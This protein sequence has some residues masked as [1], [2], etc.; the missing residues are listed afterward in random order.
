MYRSNSPTAAAMCQNIVNQWRTNLGI[1]VPLEQQES[2]TAKDRLKDKDY[3]IATA[4]WF[5]DYPDPSTFTDKYLSTAVNNDSGWVNEE[6][7]RLCDQ[8]T[9]EADAV[10]RYDLLERANRLIDIELPIIPLYVLSN[11]YLFRDNV[12]GIST[13]PRATTMV[14]GVWVER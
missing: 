7:D 4:N 13:T 5:G 12:H 6:F 11:Q 10:K 8:A 14:K 1:G 9:R 2:K 3:S